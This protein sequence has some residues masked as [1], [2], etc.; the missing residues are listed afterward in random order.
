[1]LERDQRGPVAALTAI[2]LGL[3]LQLCVST[4]YVVEV[5][6]GPRKACDAKP[7][8]TIP[9]HWLANGR[10]VLWGVLLIAFG[11]TAW[12]GA[13]WVMRTRPARWTAIAA[14]VT[15]VLLA[16]VVV[17]AVQYPPTYRPK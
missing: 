14:G 9:P 4:W 5:I 3:F 16:V 17:F 10:F 7:C 2:M 6:V 12:C 15:F 1:M 8:K 11:V 13:G